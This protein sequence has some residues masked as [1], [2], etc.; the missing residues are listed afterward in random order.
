M[1]RLPRPDIGIM[2]V[3]VPLVILLLLL[4][5]FEP[6]RAMGAPTDRAPRVVAGVDPDG[7]PTLALVNP[8][9]ACTI[10]FGGDG[11]LR[12]EVVRAEPAWLAGYGAAQAG[13]ELDGGFAWELRWNSG[14]PP[15]AGR[16]DG[17]TVLVDQRGFRYVGHATSGDTLSVRLRDDE[18]DLEADAVWTLAEADFF[19]R[20]RVALRDPD[21]RGHRLLRVWQRR[22]AIFDTARL[23]KSGERDQPVAFTVQDGGAFLG[24]DGAAA[25]N[26]IEPAGCGAVKL[27]CWEILEAPV[28]ATAA[29]GAW[30]VAAVTPAADV[31]AWLGRYRATAGVAPREP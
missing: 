8:Q 3:I 22:G 31:L 1:S 17:D 7:N 11:R 6:A 21:E 10:T 27:E 20:R 9:L 26:T 24:L 4:I 29:T 19:V 18:L 14:R 23:V 12:R 2:A 5:A 16:G 30:C 25:T 28:L 15:E 13:I